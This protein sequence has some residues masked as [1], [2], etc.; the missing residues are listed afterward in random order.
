[1]ANYKVHDNPVR[2]EWLAKIGQLNTLKSGAAFLTD[3]RKKHT[4]PF[5]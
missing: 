4:A 2:D 1:M 3:F 5:T